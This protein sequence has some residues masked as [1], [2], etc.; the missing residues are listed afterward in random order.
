MFPFTF[1]LL[2]HS[3]Q[4][5]RSFS[6]IAINIPYSW[7]PRKQF[8][9]S[10]VCQTQTTMFPAAP[11][12]SLSRLTSTHD[13]HRWN[14]LPLA[15]SSFQLWTSYYYTRLYSKDNT[16]EPNAINETESVYCLSPQHRNG[17]KQDPEGGPGT[18]G[19][20]SPLGSHTAD[21]VLGQRGAV[22]RPSCHS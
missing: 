3:L 12:C 9:Q 8:C 5:F 2:F 18:S 17:A 22:L 20:C 4:F 14:C 13:F 7:A 10:F 19:W 21:Q 16:R 1:L 15:P 11:S 6:L